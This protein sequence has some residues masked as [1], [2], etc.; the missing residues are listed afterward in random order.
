MVRYPPSSSTSSI[1]IPLGRI[2]ETGP[3]S[4]KSYSSAIEV[5]PLKEIEVAS[6]SGLGYVMP[7]PETRPLVNDEPSNSAALTIGPTIRPLNALAKKFISK[8]L[9]LPSINSPRLPS[10]SNLNSTFGI[11]TLR[12]IG[13]SS[14]IS[15]SSP[16]SPSTLVFIS[17][18]LKSTWPNG[19]SSKSGNSAPL[20]WIK[21]VII[22]P[23]SI[24]KSVRPS[25]VKISD[26][27][28]SHT[29]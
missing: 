9:E 26:K 17:K 22:S 24:E 3:F 13:S 6:P 1:V 8:L 11:F 14:P 18:P 29:E 20:C 5:F 12:V 27:F 10:N 4:V 16:V 19:E 23:T 25:G 2:T 7:L 21:A 28:S 15:W